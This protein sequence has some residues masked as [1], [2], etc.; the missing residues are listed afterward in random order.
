MPAHI[1][2][3]GTVYAAVETVI[4]RTMLDFAAGRFGSPGPPETCHLCR[5]KWLRG[6]R[7][8][9]GVADMGIGV[10]CHNPFEVDRIMRA[11]VGEDG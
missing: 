4:D 3:D 11:E 8:L 2:E 5:I 9:D 10:A 7:G 1:G 6:R